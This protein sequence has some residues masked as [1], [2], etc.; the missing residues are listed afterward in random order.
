M[1]ETLIV[2]NTASP[3][4]LDKKLELMRKRATS[5]RNVITLQARKFDK[6]PQ[7]TASDLA[8]AS[9]PI[10]DLIRQKRELRKRES[11]K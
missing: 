10:N 4:K 5:T 7:D 1:K 3:A 6:A 11:F 9:S 2:S 8:Q